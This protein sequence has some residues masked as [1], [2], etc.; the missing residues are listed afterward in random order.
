MSR[1]NY[2]LPEAGYLRLIQIIGQRAISRE[3][4][5]ANRIIGKGPRTPRP[6]IP[7]IIPVARSSWWAG[8]R[9]GRYPK[10]VKIGPRT[11]VWRVEDI[12]ALIEQAA[13]R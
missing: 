11:T 9:S 10:P 4:S 13:S 2:S 3:E 1:H 8:V 5:T 12:R 6:A 7:A